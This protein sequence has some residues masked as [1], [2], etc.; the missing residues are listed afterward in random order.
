MPE[1]DSDQKVTLE[2]T[3]L[4]FRNHGMPLEALRY[5]VTPVGL[6]YLLIHFDIPALDAHAYRLPVGGRVRQPLSL[7]L[8]ELKARE[9]V[10]TAVTLECAGNGRSLLSPRPIYVPW[11]NDAVGN[12]EWTGTPLRPI[13]EEAG[14]LDDAVEV[15]FTGW[16]R[17]IDK[18]V[19]HAFE[20]SLPIA[21]ALLD[22]VMLA[23]AVNGVDLPP[24]H[25]FPL[26][27]V[28]PGWYGMASVK[29]L[30]SITVID[31]A[32]DGFEQAV[33]YH[34]KRD[35]DDPGEPVTRMVPR[36][37]LIPPG[38]PDVLTRSRRMA[39][40][41]ECLVEGRA[42]SG[43]GEVVRVEF[44]DDDGAAWADAE[45]GA[46]ASP[47]AWRPW[48]VAWDASREG[49]YALRTRATDDSGRTQPLDEPWNHL[50]MAVNQAQRVWVTVT[51]DPSVL[52]KGA[53]ST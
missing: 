49:E 46:A 19:E 37:L 3:E 43:H 21:E 13:L 24:Q 40:E 36:S 18:G 48:R 28:V 38:I 30:R 34:I 31:H 20:R 8:G 12:A 4:A 23:W 10:T 5:P 51:S 9:T 35:A 17:G 32:F 15:V 11:F 6:H 50:G 1:P 42:W 53:W 29:W 52:P 7:S 22:E 39:P 45:L 33:N 14:L 26:R 41:R 16:D 44:S 47:H 25:G 2:E 27:L